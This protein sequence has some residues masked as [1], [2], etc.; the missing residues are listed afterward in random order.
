MTY[1]NDLILHETLFAENN[2]LAVIAGEL[3]GVAAVEA[4]ERWR[5]H[6]AMMAETLGLP[7]LP[8][9]RVN[10]R[11]PVLASKNVPVGGSKHYTRPGRAL[12]AEPVSR[13]PK[14]HPRHDEIIA[15]YKEGWTIERLR[16][17]FKADWYTIRDILTGAGVEI[18]ANTSYT[19]NASDEQ[20]REALAA[21]IPAFRIIK[22][23]HVSERR[24]VAI[25][26]AMAK[27]CA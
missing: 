12:P 22:T 5:Q 8:P 21:G 14:R 18:R 4:R 25:R 24:V 23:M 11:V 13:E 19:R 9:A 2:A 6:T 1:T 27:E 20:I 7:Q 17:D 16:N 3:S 10:R 15:L 26:K